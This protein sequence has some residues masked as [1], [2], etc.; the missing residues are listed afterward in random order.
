MCLLSV[1][2]ALWSREIVWENRVP[3]RE[4]NKIEIS[5]SDLLLL[6]ESLSRLKLTHTRCSETFI[7]IFCSFFLCGHDS[8]QRD[9]IDH[10]ILLLHLFLEECPDRVAVI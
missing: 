7:C 2:G 1:P 6:I 10:H 5:S 4:S 9:A 8:H 3:K